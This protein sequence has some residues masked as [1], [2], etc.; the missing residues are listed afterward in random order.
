MKFSRLETCMWV[1]ERRHTHSV[2]AFTDTESRH[3][4][5]TLT[6][7]SDTLHVAVFRRS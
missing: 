7:Q 6:L 3:G 4:L 1:L 5:S 2:S